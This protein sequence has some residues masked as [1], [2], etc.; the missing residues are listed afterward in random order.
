MP[1][2]IPD[3]IVPREL[4]SFVRAYLHAAEWTDCGQD[5]DADLQAAAWS[6]DAI[7]RAIEACSDFREMA[8]PL[9]DETGAGNERNGTDFWLTRNHHGAGFWDRGYGE[10]GDQL[11]DLAKTFSG[12]DTYV[13]DDGLA[14]FS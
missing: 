5:A 13:G 3:K 14:Y 7:A 8:G 9:L 4:D 10:I 1:E 2:F 6:P 12:V 11:T